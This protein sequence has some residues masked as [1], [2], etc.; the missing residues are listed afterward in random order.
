[1]KLNLEKV[2]LLMASN[3]LSIRGLS[4]KSGINYITLVPYLNGSRSPK[5]E[6]LGKI[7]K[8]LGVDPAEIIATED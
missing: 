1:M 2:K 7:A 6:K 5:T 3:C 4:E 8:A